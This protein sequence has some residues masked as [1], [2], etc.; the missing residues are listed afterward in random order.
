MNNRNDIIKKLKNEKGKIMMN[1][2]IINASIRMQNVFINN[3]NYLKDFCTDFEMTE[4]EVN[5]S[6]NGNIKQNISFYYQAEHWINEK[7]KQKKNYF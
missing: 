1:V 7:E 6:F 5:D 4:E 3:P 2:S